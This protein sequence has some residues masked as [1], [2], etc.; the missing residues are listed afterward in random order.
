MDKFEWESEQA[1]GVKM[2]SL[3]PLVLLPH[4]LDLGQLI[5]AVSEPQVPT[6]SLKSQLLLCSCVST[7]S[8]YI[9]CRASGCGLREMALQATLEV[10][11]G[12]NRSMDWRSP[13]KTLT[14][15]VL[16]CT[17]LY[18]WLIKVS[19]KLFPIQLD[20]ALQTKSLII[21]HFVCFPP[22]NR[23]WLPQ[24][25]IWPFRRTQ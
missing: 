24:S 21:I 20:V 5:S 6:G 25:Q 18:Y 14:F 16:K 8:Y 23:L 22:L 7:T 4:Y 2:W 3:L 11:L 15:Y 9:R 1:Q 13:L 12:L 17:C 10:L 19:S